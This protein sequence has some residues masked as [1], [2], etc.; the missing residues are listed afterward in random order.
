MNM[1]I[2]LCPGLPFSFKQVSLTDSLKSRLIIILPANH[3]VA[4]HEGTD[5]S[6]SDLVLLLHR[7]H[8]PE[9]GTN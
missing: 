4:V 7:G 9:G 5:L 8:K 3:I 2:P 6:S 1:K